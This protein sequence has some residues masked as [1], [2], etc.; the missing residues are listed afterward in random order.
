MSKSSGPSAKSRLFTYLNAPDNSRTREAL[1]RHRLAFDLCVAAARRGYALQVYSGEV[2]RDGFDIVLDDGDVLRKIQLKSV[3]S[4]T[5][6]WMIS[7]KLLLPE[8]RDVERLGFMPEQ[9]SSGLGGGA[10]LQE[11]FVEPN[12]NLTVRYSYT[13]AALLRAFE[14]GLLSRG[15]ALTAAAV[16]RSCRG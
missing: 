16:R 14:A 5:K 12:D 7:K 10:V 4:S 6:A 11:V 3:L 8:P 13:D 15:K 2:D 1:L 9:S